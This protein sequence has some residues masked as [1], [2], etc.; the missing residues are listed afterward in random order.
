MS[1]NGPGDG[2]GADLA[3]QKGGGV[4]ADFDVAG[5]IPKTGVTNSGM[6]RTWTQREKAVAQVTIHTATAGFEHFPQAP[7]EAV[8]YL[9]SAR[10]AS[11]PPSVPK[12]ARISAMDLSSPNSTA[13]RMRA[14][15]PARSPAKIAPAFCKSLPPPL[16]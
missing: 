6:D 5:A 14:L 12:T 1:R 2:A 13:A 7:Q 9:G 3:V 16:P 10:Q 15:A 11:Q 4:L 8:K